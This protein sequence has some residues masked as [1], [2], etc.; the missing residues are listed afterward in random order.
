MTRNRGRQGSSFVP[1]FKKIKKKIKKTLA[2]KYRIFHTVQVK[3]LSAHEPNTSQV[4]QP[5]CL[6]LF[7]QRTGLSN[8]F[9]FHHFKFLQ[10]KMPNHSAEKHSQI[11]YEKPVNT[12]LLIVLIFKISLFVCL[13]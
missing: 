13:I 2:C 10:L 6:L 12:L 9:K 7:K 8:N 11:A 3:R 5:L 1:K 4:A